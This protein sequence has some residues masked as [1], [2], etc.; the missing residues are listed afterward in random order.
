[1]K[2]YMLVKSQKRG[3]ILVE[4]MMAHFRYSVK[5]KTRTYCSSARAS[6][7]ICHPLVAA[8]FVDLKVKQC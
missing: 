5:Y 7:S 1:V 6:F 3:A 8:I 4:S 2:K